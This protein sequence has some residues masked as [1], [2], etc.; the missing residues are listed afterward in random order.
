MNE[1]A[2]FEKIIRFG[3]L[4]A[5]RDYEFSLD[6]DARNRSDIALA[7]NIPKI[8]KLRFAGRL[9]PLGAKD[10]HLAASL[11][12]TVVQDCVVSLQPVTTRID[13]PVERSYLAALP[14]TTDNEEIEMP[15]D[16]THEP[17]PPELDLGQVMLE[18]LALALPQY[19]RAPGVDP[20]EITFTEP[21]V[22]PLEDEATKPFAGLAGLRNKLSGDS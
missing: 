22:T 20:L 4:P 15:E 18:A 1:T 12:A 2:P 10:W 16:E 19:P 9:S 21:G 11:G 5:D 7:L 6:P 3:D 17:L 14:A 8:R 13:E